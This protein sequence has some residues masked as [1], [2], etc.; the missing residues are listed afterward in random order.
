M[1]HDTPEREALHHRQI[2]LRFYRLRDGHF[3]IVGHV[4][5]TKTH[6]FRLQLAPADLPAG[7][8]VH[9]M[10]VRLK[11]D[12]HMTVLD[13]SAIMRATP[14][15]VCRGAQNTLTP[16]IGLTIGAG[17]NKRVRDRLAGSASCTHLM[18][19]LGPMATTA[20]QGLAPDRI[21]E[22]EKPENEAMRKAKVN[23]CYAY[24]DEREVVAQLWPHL[25]KP[26]PKASDPT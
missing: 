14:F 17:W 26:N 8:P 24:S 3:E 11:I 7:A 22:V 6:P 25:A 16:I 9:D 13:A 4:T 2:D 21:A 5:D 19:L 23:S 1:N 10:E 15:G 20:F 18:E 12:R